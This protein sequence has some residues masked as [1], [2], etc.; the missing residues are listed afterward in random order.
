[1]FIS[2]TRLNCD[3]SLSAEVHE[4]Q[5]D[6]G[7]F[8]I[9][10]TPENFGMSEWSPRAKNLGLLKAT[11]RLC[12]GLDP[13]FVKFKVTGW[14]SPHNKVFGKFTKDAWK[15]M[16]TI[17]LNSDTISKTQMLLSKWTN[18]TCIQ[19][20]WRINCTRLMHVLTSIWTSCE[21]SIAG[22]SYIWAAN[23][24][25]IAYA[26]SEGS[27]EPAHSRSLARTSAA[28]SYKQWVKRNLQTESQIPGPS[29]WLGMSS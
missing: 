22:C 25:L 12:K 8:S 24:V 9:W 15:K 28:R 2:I 4:L 11:L 21:V 7:E 19:N 5:S 17:L 18:T 29:E 6:L 26:S 23:L 20:I 1:M 3:K 10:Y 13:V 27:G 14:T 16:W